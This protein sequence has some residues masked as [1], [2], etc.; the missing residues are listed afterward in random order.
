MA[1]AKDL[2]KKIRVI[3]NTKKITRTMEL[4]ATAKSKRAQ[5]RVNATTPYLKALGGILR[6][7]DG[8]G[9][10]KHRLLQAPEEETKTLL[11]VV[12]ANRGFCGGY[13][14][15]VLALAQMTM[16]DE[17]S[18][19]RKTEIY[20]A[21]RKGVAKFRFLRIPVA[22]TFLNLDS[23]GGFADAV[24]VADELIG[25]F[26]SGEVTK[27]LAICTHYHSAGVQKPAV[28]QLLPLTAPATPGAAAEKGK[29][30]NGGAAAARA[31]DFIFEPDPRTILD[32]LI[33][34]SVRMAFFRLV[35]EANTSEQIARRTA[36]KI[37]TDNAEDMI[38]F[39]TRFY[40]RTRQAGIT[41][42]INEI[43]GGAGALD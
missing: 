14:T 26:L 23:W 9:T 41:Q 17:E 1:S 38:R 8:S 30:K 43:V 40:N 2:K 27:V 34:F 7:L 22:K 35:L 31:T 6:A 32:A 33:P 12:S 42:Q 21:G 18:A 16:R 15:N 13:N 11:F 25:R 37:A 10:A 36:M 5:D 4:V 39:Y 28:L 3:S 24:A 29:G 20:M 19:G